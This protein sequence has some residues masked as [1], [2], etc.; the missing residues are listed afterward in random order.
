[1]NEN[2]EKTISLYRTKFE[3]SP[4]L[5]NNFQ[6]LDY[7]R[8]LKEFNMV[9]EAIKVGETFLQECPDLVDYINTY[10]Y[11]IYN[12]FINIDTK[13]ILENLEV[14]YQN[15]DKILKICKAV[16]YSPYLA[17]VNKA[18]RIINSTTPVDYHK[19][20][21][22]LNHQ[23][24][25]DLS[26]QPFKNDD[27]REFESKLERYYRLKVRALYETKNFV[28]CIETAN[29]A[30]ALN[31]KWHFN[32][33]LW[34]QHYR[35]ESLVEE[36]QFE[37]AKRAILKLGNRIH[38]INARDV[39]YKI[40]V[41][42]NEH[43]EA[44]MY[45]LLDFFEKGYTIDELE[46]YKNILS[47]VQHA[48][49]ED[50]AMIVEQ[51]IIALCQESNVPFESTITPS[52]SN[53]S[54][55]YDTMYNNIMKNLDKFTIR[56]V[57]NVSYYNETSNYGIVKNQQFEDGLFFKQTDFVYD[58]DVQ[59]RDV[60]S[61]CTL[62]TFDVKKQMISQRAVLILTEEQYIHFDY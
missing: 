10:G 2:Q 40:H 57:G 9:D 28:E 37:E 44:N 26:S 3:A 50:V 16:K 59:R 38:G 6:A 14:F 8:I 53:S 39:L 48:K 54:D 51:F 49:L 24:V 12:N 47:M 19:L 55:L 41:N 32:A 5:F 25:S 56:Q 58:E 23:I 33:H 45:L 15:V 11:L 22:L 61:F 35:V 29:T 1:M 17:T 18:I 42:N 43:Q 36:R 52:Q 34:I 21:E 30:L 4:N 27:G 31:L 60:I 13:L 7:M 62:P 46:M 20:L